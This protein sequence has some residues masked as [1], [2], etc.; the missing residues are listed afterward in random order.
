MS[1]SASGI[2][3]GTPSTTTPIAGPW[4]SPQVVKRNSVPKLLPAI[5]LLLPSH[6]RDVRCV[7]ALHADHVI[8]AIDMMDFAANP[9]RQIAQQ[10]K[11]GAADILDRDIALQRRIVLVPFQDVVEVADP[12]RSERSD[13]S[14]RDRVDADIVATEIDSE[15][16]NA[17]LEPRLRDT[18]DVL[19]RHDPLSAEIVQRPQAAAVRP[20]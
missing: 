20:Q 8:T 12:G 18:N 17:R 14:G 16:A 3:G 13:R 9:G 5:G 2:R 4:L 11:P 6:D 19:V 7:G 1:G 15:I 10:I